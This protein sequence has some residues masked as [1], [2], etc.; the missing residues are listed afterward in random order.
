MGAPTVAALAERAPGERRVAL[1]PDVAARLV[2]QGHAVLVERGAGAGALVPDEA[3][4]AVG[5]EVVELDEALARADV[6]LAVR[7]PEREVLDR[8]RPGQVLLGLLDA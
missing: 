7:R 5:A 1:V 3:F 4:T 8:L 2:G 6:V